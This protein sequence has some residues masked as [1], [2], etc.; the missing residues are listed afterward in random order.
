MGEAKSEIIN[1]KKLVEELDSCKLI[2]PLLQRNYKWPVKCSKESSEASVE[3][4]LND[5]Y[6]KYI[7]NSAEHLISMITL[8]K[9]G[10]NIYII[11]GQ[12]RLITIALIVKVLGYY[13]ENDFFKLEFERDDDKNNPIRQQYLEKDFTNNSVDIDNVDVLH[14]NEAVKFINNFVC[15]K[16]KNKEKF[17]NYIKDKIK[18][19]VRFT[20]NE[21]LQEFLNLNEKKTKFSSTDYD[22]AYQIKYSSNS[23]TNNITPAMI[24]NEHSEIQNYL[25]T[26]DELYYLIKYGYNELP[27]RMDYIFEKI[28]KDEVNDISIF[29]EELDAKD[30]EN[31]KEVYKER[32]KYLVYC[33]KVLRSIS[34]ELKVRNESKL[35]VNVVNSVY[36]LYKKNPNIKFFDLIDINDLE[37]KS[38]EEIVKEKFNLYQKTYEYMKQKNCF[39]ESVL[40]KDINKNVIDTN[41]DNNYLMYQEDMKFANDDLLK[42]FDNRFN[43]TIAMIE[44]GKNYLNE[45]YNLLVQNGKD[46]NNNV[47]DNQNDDSK[48]DNGKKSFSEILGNIDI[49]YVIIPAIQ[50]DYT[51]GSIKNSVEELL[52]DISKTYISACIGK[53]VDEYEKGSAARL[54]AYYLNDGKFWESWETWRKWGIVYRNKYGTEYCNKETKKLFENA[55]ISIF[56]NGSD[57]RH[58]DVKDWIYYKAFG[59]QEKLN[60]NL[61]F[62]NFKYGD[63]FAVNNNDKKFMFSV[64]FGCFMNNEFYIYDGQQRIVTLVYLAAYIIN[65]TYNEENKEKYDNWKNLLRKFKFEKREKANKLLGKLLDNKKIDKIEDLKSFIADHTTYSICKLLEFYENYQNKFGTNII[66]FN[67]DFI[68]NNIFFEFAI[69]K[70]M[71]IAD[72]MYIDLNSK[73]IALTPYENYK[74]EL[75]YLLSTKFVDEYDKYWKFKLDNTYL[76]E[77][78]KFVNKEK[79]TWNK[80]LQDKAEELEIKIIHWCFKMAAMELGI[81]VGNIIVNESS[82]QINKEK[83]DNSRLIWMDNSNAGGIIECAR[84]VL[85]RIFEPLSKND[86][87]YLNKIEEFNNNNSKKFN[88][89]SVFYLDEFEFWF[90]LRRHEDKESY[91]FKFELQKFCDEENTKSF[92][93]YNIINDEAISLAKYWFWLANKKG[94]GNSN[95][96]DGKSQNSEIIKFL[97]KKYHTFWE[98]GY[99]ETETIEYMN[100]CKDIS[101]NQNDNL[102]NQI[103]NSIEKEYDYFSENYLTKKPDYIKDWIEYIYII[104]LEEMLNIKEYDNVKVWEKYEFEGKK[105]FENKDKRI[106]IEK[107]NGNYYLWN[108]LNDFISKNEFKSIGLDINNNLNTINEL[109]YEIINSINDDGVLNICLFDNVFNEKSK[110][111]IKIDFTQNESV[112]EEVYKYIVDLLNNFNKEVVEKVVNKYLCF[113]NSDSYV[114]YRF[115]KENKN[116]EETNLIDIGNIIIKVEDIKQEIKEK[117][118][119]NNDI[120]NIICYYWLKDPD[121]CIEN[122]INNKISSDSIIDSLKKWNIDIDSEELNKKF[123]TYN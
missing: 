37:K 110:F 57:F 91:E 113:K 115:N 30:E 54:A 3:K 28:K 105:V 59:W 60:K 114:M 77:C 87:E 29:Y 42:F 5:I 82:N 103:D 35:N 47:A 25:Y 66:S 33:H 67:L 22:R 9:D 80:N 11:D 31:K 45:D 15:D 26:C 51:L 109:N 46:D 101:E 84:N 68:M 27:N 8:Y 88:D 55:G 122:A 99:F 24:L 95:N 100:S 58:N 74:A 50:R 32:Y 104:K 41:N 98:G 92:K 65:Q 4:L 121:E 21:P 10:N 44:K 96:I 72:Q 70:E 123:L 7:N 119:S 78:Y 93:V 36:M 39:L 49:N 16:I 61:D 6:N 23:R 102:E 1:F 116:W 52:Y 75:V 107:L 90:D 2:I 79:D 97:L 81:S 89:Y 76:D 83:G 48:L 14:M 63:Y 17:F 120:K 112:K 108:F 85:E 40:Y 118:S 71:G 56:D 86:N 12:Q 18:M 62:E 111:D 20:Y 34:Q 64:L 38:F 94:E 69:V 117:L 53:K 19:I 73:N 43:D 13:N 106:A